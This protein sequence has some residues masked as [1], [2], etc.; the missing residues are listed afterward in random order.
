MAYNSNVPLGNQRVKDTQQPI[1]N[2]FGA[3]GAAL[4]NVDT[5]ACLFPQ[6][7]D[8]N[9]TATQVAL[10]QK[11]NEL[12][13]RRASNGTVINC[14]ERIPAA[15]GWTRL[16]SGIVLA[17]LNNSVNTDAVGAFTLNAGFTSPNL[18]AVYAIIASVSSPGAVPSTVYATTY[19]TGT[20]VLSGFIYRLDDGQPL[21]TG[22]AAVQ[23]L[24]IGA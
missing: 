21:N 6:I 17:W 10:Y 3:L 23:V 2:N 5:L 20:D 15:N 18:T 22:N 8:P 1:L 14:T 11:N 12:Y 7:T 16:P 9:T 4:N 13:F 24:I 19:N